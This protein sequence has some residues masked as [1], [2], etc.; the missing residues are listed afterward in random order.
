MSKNNKSK[1]IVLR[2]LIF[3]LIGFLFINS[4]Y[5]ISEYNDAADELFN[6]P[7]NIKGSVLNVKDCVSLA[8]K[9]SPKVRRKKYE[10]DIA[11][12]NIGLAKS[13]YFP[14]FNAGVG[15]NYIR[16]T[17]GIYYD[18]KY[19]DLPN[20][21]VALNQLIYDFGKTSANIKMEKFYKIAAEY[22]FVDELCHTLFD[23]KE[24]YYSLLKAQALYLLA[25]KNIE[26]NKRFEQIA[27]DKPDLLTAQVNL[28]A[29]K[30]SSVEAQKNLENAKFNLSNSMYLDNQ[31]EYNIKQT[32][33]FYYDVNTI[34]QN[35]NFKQV[36]FP[37]KNEDA[38]DI[39]Y[40]NSPDIEVLLNTKKAME[41]SL[42]YAK[43]SYMPDLTASAGYQLN[44]T[45]NGTNNS[46]QL[47]VGLSTQINAKEVKHNIDIAKAQLNIADNEI[48]LFKKDLY[49]DVQRALNN[50][51]RAEKQLP[52]SKAQ[53]VQ[54]LDNLNIVEDGYK[55][56]KLD[57]VA[58]QNARREYISSHENYINSLYD[59]NMSIIQ[60]E[61]AMHYHLVDIHHK[62]EHALHNHTDELIEHLNEA[63]NCNEKENRTK[64]KKRKNK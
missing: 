55:K 32:P 22:E 35:D 27:Y 62:T 5:A 9:N 59:Y 8:F 45:Y 1:N 40:K 2:S 43:K 21:G 12:S 48:L 47:G 60:I 50:F 42:K 23:I 34:S 30:I 25:Q 15:Y 49:Y 57:Y 6:P 16:N 28:S 13:A 41:Q 19:R 51:Y 64:N 52:V 46:F 44:D 20:V 63:L 53:T 26:L 31:I 38:A 39:A 58:L 33:T 61:M 7:Q 36:V 54:A 17:D 24:K 18:K 3:F 11:K 10:L 56:K 29:A 4:S 37:F 14:V